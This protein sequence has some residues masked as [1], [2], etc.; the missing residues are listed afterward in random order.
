[1][2]RNE[3]IDQIVFPG[4][5]CETKFA[6]MGHLV[7]IA[8]DGMSLRACLNSWLMTCEQDCASWPDAVCL[9]S[10]IIS[11]HGRNIMTNPWP[12]FEKRPPATLEG[13]ADPTNRAARRAV[14]SDMR[15]K[16]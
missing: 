10:P 2:M 16:R 7:F 12:S 8:D 5:A 9:G 11:G 4:E 6:Q 13:F 14:A 1:M 3:P 15:R